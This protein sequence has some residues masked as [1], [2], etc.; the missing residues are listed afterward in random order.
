MST[1]FSYVFE[2]RS[3]IPTITNHKSQIY[4]FES[5]TQ[6]SFGYAPMPKKDI[7]LQLVEDTNMLCKN[8]KLIIPASL[9]HRAVA[10]YHHYLQHPG[11]S[12]LKE[13]M[14]SVMYWKGM[15]TTIQRYMKSCRSCQVNK[16]HSLRYGR[17]PP[18]LVIT[19]SW[20]ALCV[21][22]VGPYTL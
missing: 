16:T 17:V 11:H 13:T 7:C 20:R 8:G 18:K 12:R 22:L 19:I 2:T 5:Q 21:D 6:M 4:N 10:W 14:R 1:F 9:Q 15:R 3:H